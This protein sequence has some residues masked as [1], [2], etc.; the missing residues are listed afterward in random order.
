MHKIFVEICSLPYVD[1]YEDAEK[2]YYSMLRKNT[3]F[4]GNDKA[5]AYI[6]SR[7]WVHTY[8]QALKLYNETLM[9][10]FADDE[11]QEHIFED[12][13]RKLRFN[14]HENYHRNKKKNCRCFW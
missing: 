3:Q 2:I 10:S 6:A 14:K 8:K 5:F 13:R 11:Y 12:T 7:K 4:Q 1:T 9:C